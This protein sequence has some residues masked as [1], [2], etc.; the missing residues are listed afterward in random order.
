MAQA[1]TMAFKAL[2]LEIFERFQEALMLVREINPKLVV[3]QKI[4]KSKAK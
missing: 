3:A 4:K 2:V 1:V